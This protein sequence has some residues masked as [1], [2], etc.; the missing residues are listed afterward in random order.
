MIK[1]SETFLL[2]LGLGIRGSCSVFVQAPAVLGTSLPLT[3][4]KAEAVSDGK[5]EVMLRNLISL[6]ILVHRHST[7]GRFDLNPFFPLCSFADVLS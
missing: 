4:Q 7:F 2:H 1:V 5:V 6:H 3:C